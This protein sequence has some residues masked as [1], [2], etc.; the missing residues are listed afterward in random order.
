MDPDLEALISPY[1]HPD[2]AWN[3][4]VEMAVRYD[5]ALKNKNNQ[6]STT[7]YSK[8][9]SFQRNFNKNN[10]WNN[11]PKNFNKPLNKPFNKSNNNNRSFRN[12]NK[13]K[14][15]NNKPKR[16][17]ATVTCYNC[18]EKAHYANKCPKKSIKSA[19]QTVQP[20]RM[21]PVSLPPRGGPWELL[22]GVSDA[23]R[24]RG[25]G[26]GFRYVCSSFSGGF[27]M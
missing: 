24:D 22:A 13:S 17:L 5:T 14:N 3:E 4:I 23:N 19:A 27:G 12:N 11:K 20:R 9:P 1:I 15:F 7:N 25:R 2:M 16:D 8:K 10:N 6:K 26:G 21:G 18:N